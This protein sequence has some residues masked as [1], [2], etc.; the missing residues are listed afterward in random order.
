MIRAGLR[1]DEDM[2]AATLAVV[3]DLVTCAE[4]TGEVAESRWRM[5]LHRASQGLTVSGDALVSVVRQREEASHRALQAKVEARVS[6][7][8]ADL[9]VIEV[10]ERI[11][12]RCQLSAERLKGRVITRSSAAR[13]EE[14]AGLRKR[15]Y[16]LRDRWRRAETRERLEEL[17]PIT[18]EALSR[19]ERLLAHIQA[20]GQGAFGY[21]AATPVLPVSSPPRWSQPPQPAEP[22][23]TVLLSCGC[24]TETFAEGVENMTGAHCPTHGLNTVMGYGSVTAGRRPGVHPVSADN[25]IRLAH[26]TSRYSWMSPPRRSVRRCRVSSGCSIVWGGVRRD[27]SGAC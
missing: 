13:I 5:V 16:R 1:A 15:L 26:A 22:M 4:T 10:A 23:I 12:V 14:A 27:S 24:T 3:A 6:A 11:A 17:R 20:E 21:G 25:P 18:E 9:D 7:E 8:R 2:R 19:A